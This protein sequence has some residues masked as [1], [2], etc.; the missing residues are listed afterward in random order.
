M[1]RVDP[2]LGGAL[3]SKYLLLYQVPTLTIEWDSFVLLTQ[4]GESSPRAFLV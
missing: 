3:A 1:D 2:D 4:S